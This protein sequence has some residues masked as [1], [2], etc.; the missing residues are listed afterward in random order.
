MAIIDTEAGVKTQLKPFQAVIE[1][2]QGDIARDLDLSVHEFVPWPGRILVRKFPKNTTT[3]GGLKLQ[4]SAQ[5]E[6]NWGRVVAV[7]TGSDLALVREGTVVVWLEGAG[8]PLDN[9]GDG[10][11]LLDFRNDFDHD[12]LGFFPGSES[13]SKTVGED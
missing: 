9:L 8:V 7:P 4:E 2:V 6:K 1:D 12:L 13:S 11:I 3:K 5:T 10:L